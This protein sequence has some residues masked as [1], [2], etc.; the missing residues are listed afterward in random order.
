MSIEDISLAVM[1]LNVFGSVNVAMT[2]RPPGI[3]GSHWATAGGLGNEDASPAA[4]EPVEAD[5]PPPEL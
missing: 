4:P 5:E 2:I 1:G 3:P